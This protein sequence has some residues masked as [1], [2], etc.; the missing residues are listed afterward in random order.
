[1]GNT[2]SKYV[3]QEYSGQL[4]LRE[5]EVRHQYRGQQREGEEPSRA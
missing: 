5:L 4:R 1:M 3:R 2:W